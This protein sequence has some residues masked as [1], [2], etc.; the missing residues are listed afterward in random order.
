[1]G[2]VVTSAPNQ[3][4]LREVVNLAWPLVVN[5]SVWTLQIAVDRAFLA[6]HNSDELAAT[7]NAVVLFWSI[8][9]LFFFTVLYSWTF[10]AQYGGAGRPHRIGP[11][12]GQALYF[13]LAS[14]ILILGLIPIT[15]FI[16][17]LIKHEPHLQ[18]LEVTYFQILCW[19]G[20]PTL[21][22]AAC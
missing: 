5:N 6:H 12:I 22:T 8:L 7:L 11:V 15:P 1:M 2:T 13:A 19:T 21:V 9:N 18:A 14:G 16:F 4:G 17:A 3:S 20:L 10:V